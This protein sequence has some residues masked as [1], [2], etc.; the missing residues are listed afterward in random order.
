MM[1]TAVV[2]L[3]CSVPSY[4]IVVPCGSQPAAV[5]GFVVV[6]VCVRAC[7]WYRRNFNMSSIL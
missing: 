3:E 6:F 5:D 7:T 1:R 4:H 2:T